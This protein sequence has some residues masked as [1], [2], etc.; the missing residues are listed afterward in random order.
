[1]HN[2]VRAISQIL[3]RPKHFDI[4]RLHQYAIDLSDIDDKASSKNHKQR[5]N[6]MEE[7][8]VADLLDSISSKRDDKD[9]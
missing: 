9:Q 1:M 8:Q 6:T 5:K 3:F 4:V 2:L 7:Q